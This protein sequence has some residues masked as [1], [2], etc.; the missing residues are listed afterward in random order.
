[1]TSKHKAFV[2]VCFS[3]LLYELT[4]ISVFM[5]LNV[6]MLCMCPAKPVCVCMCVIVETVYHYFWVAE[7]WR[8]DQESCG[9]HSQKSG[10]IPKWE[11]KQSNRKDSE[12]TQTSLDTQIHTDR[13]T[14]FHLRVIV[15]ADPLVILAAAWEEKREK[16]V[17]GRK[18]KHSEHQNKS[19]KICK[20]FSRTPRLWKL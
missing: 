17:T 5:H 12:W 16:K 14:H 1:M 3:F 18:K 2:C 8:S 7:V 20:H 13:H 10:F 15:P 4:Q 6:H 19:K 11:C 9:R